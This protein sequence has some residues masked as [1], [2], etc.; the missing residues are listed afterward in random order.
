MAPST[1]RKE[2]IIT[3]THTHTHTQCSTHFLPPLLPP[4][5]THLCSNIHLLLCSLIISN[6]SNI[7]DF[8]LLQDF[9]DY[10]AS[11]SY[12]PTWREGGK[13]GGKEKG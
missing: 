10:V 3:H 11:L 4:T 2:R 6:H 12:H 13:E 1:T 7:V 5:P 9:L 8:G